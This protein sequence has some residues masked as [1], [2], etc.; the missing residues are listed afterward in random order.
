MT[1]DIRALEEAGKAVE[2]SHKTLQSLLEQRTQ[3][4]IGQRENEIVLDEFEFLS[5]T[6]VVMKQVGP[7]LVRE[8]L[9]AA[10]QNVK[11]RLDYMANQLKS[12]DSKIEA[13]QKIVA[14]AETKLAQMQARIK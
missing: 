1:L 11:Q 4:F 12:L 14:A 9:D 7:T 5:D 10:K 3:I 8:E 6:D 2:E 13:T